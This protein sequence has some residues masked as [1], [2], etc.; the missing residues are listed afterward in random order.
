VAPN[1]WGDPW[2]AIGVS[3]RG[4]GSGHDDP[5][6]SNVS[7]ISAPQT[8][9]VKHRRPMICWPRIRAIASCIQHQHP[10]E[11]PLEHRIPLTVLQRRSP[12]PN[13]GGAIAP[14]DTPKEKC[15]VFGIWGGDSPAG[16]T[17][18]A[19]YAQQHRG[20]ESAGMAVT[21]GASIISRVG[22][23]L[24]PEVFT[25]RSIR[26]FHD[27][28]G[29]EDRGQASHGMLR[30]VIGHNRYSTTGG[31][32]KINA[33]PIVESY[34]AGQVAVA[35]NGN[36][37][38][39][40]PIRKEFELQGRI[41]H[42]TSDTEIVVHVLASP[43]QQAA[44]DPLAATLR[45]LQGAF[46]MVFLFNDRIEAA[47]DPWGWRPLTLGQ[48]PD[49]APVVASE[50]VA[51]HAIG[52]TVI[53]DVEP[54]E[55]VT[56]SD[57]GVSSRKFAEPA[58]RR[59]HCV[60]EHVYFA[61]PASE[62]FGQSVQIVRETLGE[63]LAQESPVEADYVMPMPDSGRSAANGY[64]RASGIPYR[65]GIVPNRYVGRTFIKP[66]QDARAA[67]VRLKLNVVAEI[68]RD[69]RLI[70]VDD[71]IVRGTTTKLKMTQL[72]DAGA[73]EIH[74]RISCP[75]IRFPCFFGVDFAEPSQLVAVNRTIDEIRDFLGVD[76]L[77]FLSLDGLLECAQTERIS[78]EHYCA[79]CYD[80]EYRI[81]IEHPLTKSI[82]EQGQI[83]MFSKTD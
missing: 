30:G 38:N 68:V 82:L 26:G 45:K 17:Y 13:A 22:M 63:R 66:T 29:R 18:Y 65:E 11:I 23:G 1:W 6:D 74:L 14:D 41:F 47:R 75:P 2:E 20:Q 8:A 80:G 77:A 33:Q 12:G 28:A 59:A 35:H 39:A 42:S 37:V 62:V 4:C 40:V 70:V 27:W 44:L 67:A 53:R 71:S 55:I 49:G 51:L 76:S 78:R 16:S 7:V 60:F 58:P 83:P 15:G 56:L 31:S 32:Q 50:T 72:R 34:V 81:D 19:L 64:A 43:E 48:M 24:V 3:A 21:D 69:K 57:E 10:D 73:K 61:S 54:G 5:V 9:P 52:A 46:S 79:A 36:L 25:E